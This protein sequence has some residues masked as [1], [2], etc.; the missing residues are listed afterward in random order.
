MGGGDYEPP[1]RE[2]FAHE[3]GEQTVPFCV[4]RCRRFIHQP[5]LPPD[6]EEPRDR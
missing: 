5:D 3:I 6:G 1:A 2:M 4:Q